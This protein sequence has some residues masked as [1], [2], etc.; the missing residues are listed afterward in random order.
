[1]SSADPKLLNRARFQIPVLW[2]CPRESSWHG[3]DGP[4]STA[5]D[6]WS[7]HQNNWRLPHDSDCCPGWASPERSPILAP[8]QRTHARCELVVSAFF[9]AFCPPQRLHDR[10]ALQAAA[11]GLASAEKEVFSLL[12]I[13]QKSYQKYALRYGPYQWTLGFLVKREKEKSNFPD[14][15][16][17]LFILRIV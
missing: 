6:Q 8:A 1:M 3:A 7:R 12:E 15:S 17:Q 10:W 16:V 14:F 11:Q 2:H 9:P 4:R 13:L 5:V